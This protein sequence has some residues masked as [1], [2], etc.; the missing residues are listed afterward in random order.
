MGVRGYDFEAFVSLPVDGEGLSGDALGG[1]VEV[2][3][4]VGFGGGSSEGYFARS[5]EAVE[6]A[7]GGV[8]VVF[9]GVVFGVGGFVLDAGGDDDGACNG[10]WVFFVADFELVLGEA[11]HVVFR[12]LV[13]DD[14]ENVGVGGYVV[15][16]WCEGFR[17]LPG[18]EDMGVGV[19][20]LGHGGCVFWFLFV[21][22]GWCRKCTDSFVG[23]W[24]GS[25]EGW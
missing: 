16:G 1:S 8:D 18:V 22:G 6:D 4:D 3:A 10:H 5:V 25:V 23:K 15:F 13:A 19:F 7:G 2:E 12:L 17:C 21:G 9:L 20:V 24:K 11:G 14:L